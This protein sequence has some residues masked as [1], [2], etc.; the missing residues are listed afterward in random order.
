M[1]KYKDKVDFYM[2]LMLK[3]ILNEVQHSGLQEDQHFYISFNTNCTGVKISK[4][5]HR[6]YP[7]EMLIIIQHEFDNLVVDDQ[8]FSVS[9]IFDDVTEH[10][11][12]SFNSLMTFVDPNANFSLSFSPKMELFDPSIVQHTTPS[13]VI[14]F[15]KMG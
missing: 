8:G 1:L 6:Q 14:M 5:L 12:I 9:L 4:Q 13:N 7:D 10:I 2:K 11:Y 3:D 15:P